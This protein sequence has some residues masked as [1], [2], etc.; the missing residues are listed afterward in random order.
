MSRLVAVGGYVPRFRLPAGAVEEAWGQFHARGIEQTAIPDADE[1]ALTMAHVAARRALDAADRDAGSVARLHLGTTTPPLAEE[2]LTAR[3]RSTLGLSAGVSTATF[4]G[5]TRA[6]VQAL[7]AACDADEVAIVIASDCPRGAPESAIEHAAGAG[8]A[9]ILLA[10]EGRGKIVDVASHTEPYPGTRF[11]KGGESR[12][13]QAGVT[14]YERRAFRETLTGA[15][16]RLDADIERVDAAAL[17]APDGDRPRRVAASIGIPDRTL[18]AGLTVE[19]TGDLGAASAPLGLASALSNG[20]DSVLV[21]GYGSGGGA[22]AMLIEETETVPTSIAI[23][24]EVALSYAAALRQRGTL[25]G[26]P[27]DGGGAHVSFPSWR[28]TLP[29]R[30]RLEA[31]ACRSCE[32]LH[33]PPSGVCRRCGSR[34]GF[35]PVALSRTGS[36]V[37]TTTIHSGG[38]P[39]EFAEQ[40]S[41]S[42]AYDSAIV[43]MEASDDRTVHVPL[44]IIRADE[45]TVEVGDRVETTIRLLYEQEGVPRYGRKGVPATVSR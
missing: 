13:R 39:P 30:H 43:A 40:Q 1:D 25:M 45:D 14:Q 31:G 4:T 3:L 12:T 19:E 9:A 5:S 28:Q 22:T 23:E 8:A 32:E 20:A 15:T 37:A 18:E 35:K 16:E 17:Q 11:R 42:G 26:D 10:P 36:V 24:G 29:Q 44:Q 38:A 34:E 33:F 21:A 27:V 6:G 41:R 2:D 7:Q